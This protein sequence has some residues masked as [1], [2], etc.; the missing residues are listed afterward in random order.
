MVKRRDF[1]TLLAGS[2]AAW[3]LSARAQQAAVPVVAFV[4]GRS[5]LICEGGTLALKADPERCWRP[6]E[7]VRELRG[8]DELTPHHYPSMLY[9]VCFS[10]D[11][12]L[13]AT[14]DKVGRNDP[15]PCGSGKKYKNCCGR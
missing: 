9:A 15:C 7:L 11:G 3:P 2:A 4:S 5:T 1:I 12:K 8:H 6:D 14:G 13:L 10:R